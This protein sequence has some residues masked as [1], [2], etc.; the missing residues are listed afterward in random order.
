MHTINTIGALAELHGDSFS[1]HVSPLEVD[2]FVAVDERGENVMSDEAAENSNEG[3]VA[4]KVCISQ[5]S[6]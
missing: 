4:A 3:G 6:L 5:T 1:R 2:V